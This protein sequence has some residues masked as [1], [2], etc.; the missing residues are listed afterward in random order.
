M[1]PAQAWQ[2]AAL[3]GDI[4]GQPLVYGTRVYVATENDSVYALDAATGAVIWQRNVGTP[5]PDK[6]TSGCGDIGNV[7]ITST[8]VIDTSTGRIFAVADTWDGTIASSIK[9][10]LVGFNLADGSPAPGL[11]VFVDPAGSHPAQQ[12]QRV[13][14]ALDAGQI[15]IGFGGNAGDCGD[16]HGR[17]VSVA[18]DGGPLSSFEVEASAQSGEGAIWGP[19]TPRRSVGQSARLDRQRRQRPGV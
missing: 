12:L 3:D 1:P 5:V 8:P 16:Y 18:E 4:Y 9:H 15:V 6:P 14:L 2:S 13:G 7:G 19:A 11:P 10:L 17:L